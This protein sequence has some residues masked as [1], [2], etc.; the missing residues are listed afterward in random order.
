MVREVFELW[1]RENTDPRSMEAFHEP[2]HRSAGGSPARFAASSEGAGE[3]PALQSRR[4]MVPMHAPKRKEALHE[5][6]ELPPG[7]GLR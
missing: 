5:P 4:F 2:N 6:R 1:V 7:F 3:S